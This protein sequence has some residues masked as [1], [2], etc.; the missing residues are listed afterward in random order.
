VN[1]ES[2]FRAFSRRLIWPL[3]LIPIRLW[4]FLIIPAYQRIPFPNL[5]PANWM[6]NMEAGTDTILEEFLAFCS[7]P[8]DIPAFNQLSPEQ[9]RI[10]G[11]GW[12]SLILIAYGRKLAINA[13]YFP[14]TMNLLATIPGLQSAMFSVFMPGTKLA[15][16]RGPYAGL[17]RYHLGLIVPSNG[18][19]YLQVLQE[20]KY[21]SKG[22]SLL[23][24]DSFEHFAVNDSTEIRVVLFVD[25]E[26]P[27]PAWKVPLNKAFIYVMGRSPFISHMLAKAEKATEELRKA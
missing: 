19:C 8:Q 2:T 13:A 25:V 11:Q 1:T 18:Q 4:E 21:W 5:T 20:K 12:K 24:D 14:H 26:R 17:W 6:N 9:Q 22:K 16:H 3:L 15:P 10:A 7:D 27:L 23:F